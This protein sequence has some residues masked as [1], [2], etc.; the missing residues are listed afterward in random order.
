M[1]NRIFFKCRHSTKEQTELGHWSSCE[2][3]FPVSTEFL[4]F[5]ILKVG[6]DL[7]LAG[8][9]VWLEMFARYDHLG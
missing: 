7:N 6:Q 8:G 1:K 4:L 3:N 9:L 2:H 5:L